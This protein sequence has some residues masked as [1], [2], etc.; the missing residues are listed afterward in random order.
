MAFMSSHLLHKYHSHI[1]GFLKKEKEKGKKILILVF[2]PSLL[3]S[4]LRFFP[5]I[6]LKYA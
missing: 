4:S 2:Q 3:C 5:D 1:N 6:T